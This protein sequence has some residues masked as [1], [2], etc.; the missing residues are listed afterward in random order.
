MIL[1]AWFFLTWGL[2]QGNVTAIGPFG[3]VQWCE[4]NR[5]AHV[6]RLPRAQTTPCFDGDEVIL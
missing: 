5:A 4:T 2:G 6:Q 3:T 1:L